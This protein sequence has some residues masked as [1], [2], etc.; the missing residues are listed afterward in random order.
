MIINDAKQNQINTFYPGAMAFAHLNSI[1]NISNLSN[2]KLAIVSPDGKD[3]MVEH[4]KNLHNAVINVIF[5]AGQAMPLF[6]QQ[7]LAQSISY[8]KYIIVNEYECDMMLSKLNTT[9]ANLLPNLNAFIVTMADKGA[10]L[11]NQ[12]NPNGLMINGFVA[13]NII[14]PTG[15]GDAFRAGFIYALENNMSIEEAIRIGNKMGSHKI[16]Y[17]GGQGYPKLSIEEFKCAV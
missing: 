9:I 16:A 15:C 2:Y 13:Q 10:C 11:Y 1:N 14:D 17:A 12:K 4:V 3:G 7:E 6:S 5:D 8:S